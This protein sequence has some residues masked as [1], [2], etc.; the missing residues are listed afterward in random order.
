VLGFELGTASPDQVAAAVSPKG[1]VQPSGTNPYSGGPM[2]KADG[3]AFSVEG[4]D[5]VIFIFD[6]AQH[7]KA[8]V[9]K[10]DKSRFD[11]VFE[12]LKGK[13]AVVASEVPRVGDKLVRFHEG[14]T[15]IELGA[16]HMSFEMNVRYIDDALLAKFEAASKKEAIEK[17][18]QE[19]SQF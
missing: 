7:L 14:T 10:M 1:K 19:A 9:M 18:K 13:Y 11:T 6:T 2:L 16:A 12:R 17:E 3:S 4:L 15:T 5:E 8:V